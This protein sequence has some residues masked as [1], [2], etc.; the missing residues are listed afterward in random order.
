[1]IGSEINPMEITEAATTPVV[2]ASS[3]PTKI[4]AN[5]RP[6]R[7]GPN[8]WPMVSSRSSAMPLRSRMSPMKVKNGTASSVSFDMIAQMRCGSAWKSVG[9]SNPSS[10]PPSPKKMPMAA[11]EKATG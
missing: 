4:T 7:S 5:A 2:A 3:A 8:T 1:M 9:C 10:I 11:R 6:P